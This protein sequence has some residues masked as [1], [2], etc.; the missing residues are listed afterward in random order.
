MCIV[1]LLSY[2]FFTSRKGAVQKNESFI[3][4]TDVVEPMGDRLRTG[5][6]LVTEMDMIL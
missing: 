1:T 6:I 4:L 5:V 3:V 2:L